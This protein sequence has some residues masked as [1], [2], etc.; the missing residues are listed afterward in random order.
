MFEKKIRLIF[1]RVMPLFNLGKCII[2]GIVFYKHISSFTVFH[3]QVN[4][5]LVARQM[6]R[7]GV[8][9]V[10]WTAVQNRMPLCLY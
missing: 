8:P 5:Q 6:S 3:S 10:G 7:Y 9:V 1:A 4:S 2:E